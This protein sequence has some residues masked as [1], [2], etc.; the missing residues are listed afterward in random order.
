[1]SEDLPHLPAGRRLSK[2]LE[3]AADGLRL[4]TVSDAASRP[5]AWIETFR[6]ALAGLSRQNGGGHG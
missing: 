5:A 2:R 6:E 3:L 4:A 1:M